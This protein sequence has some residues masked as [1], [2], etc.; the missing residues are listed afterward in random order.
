MK[1]LQAPEETWAAKAAAKPAEAKFALVGKEG[2]VV[3]PNPKRKENEEQ[4]SPLTRHKG[5]IPLDQRMV[6]FTRKGS[7]G[8]VTLAQKARITTTVNK[9]LF[10]AAPTNTHVRVEMVRCCP[11][12]TITASATMGVDAKMLM[13][14]RKQILEAAIKVEP[15]IIDVGTNETWRKLKIMGVQ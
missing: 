11:E 2:K 8:E 5:S 15:T 7:M 14:F 6:V 1:S 12:G 13:L 4:R 10:A 9:A 3:Q